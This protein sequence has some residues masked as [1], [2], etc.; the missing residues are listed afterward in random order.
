MLGYIL[1]QIELLLLIWMLTRKR[2]FGSS[3]S[4]TPSKIVSNTGYLINIGLLQ[5][6]ETGRSYFDIQVK[7]WINEIIVTIKIF[8]IKKVFLQSNSETRSKL[9]I[10]L[11]IAQI[12]PKKSDLELAPP[13]HHVYWFLGKVNSFDCFN[14]NSPKNRF[15]VGNSEN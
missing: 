8:L 7:W 9:H 11:Y 4:T 15:I 14:T 6:R 2:L 3:F 12:C 5:K 13:R 10:D 1:D